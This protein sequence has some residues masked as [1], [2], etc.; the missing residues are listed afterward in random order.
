MNKNIQ[1]ISITVI[2]IISA[3]LVCTGWA[4]Y[5][6]GWGAKEV[7]DACGESDSYKIGMIYFSLIFNGACDKKWFKN[8]AW[9]EE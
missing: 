3:L 2:F 5:P 4:I 1:I 9:Y 7:Q 6:L 8:K